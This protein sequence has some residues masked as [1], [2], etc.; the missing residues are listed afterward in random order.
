MFTSRAHPKN[1]GIGYAMVTISLLVAVYYNVILAYTLYYLAQSFRSVLPW[2]DCY[3]WWGAD[4]D[5]CF[6][7]Q[8]NVTLCQNIPYLLYQKYSTY[9][10]PNESGSWTPLT[11]HGSMFYVPLAE[12]AKLASSCSDFTGTTSAAEQFWERYVLELSPGIEYVGGLKWD[13]AFCLFVSWVIVFFC[14]IQGVSSSGKV[15]YFTAT[16]PYLVLTILLIKGV[17]LEGA[18]LGIEYFLV[19]DFSKLTS[20]TIWQKAAEQLFYSLGIGWGG[21]IMSGSY[22]NFRTA[23]AIDST[24]IIIADVLTSFLGG[25]AIFSVL[26][27]MSVTYGV[28]VDEVA[29]AGQGLAFVVYPEALTTFWC[30]QLWSVIFFV[31]LYLLGID[32]EFP[33]VQ[34]CLTVLFDAFPILRRHKS[35]TA[36]ITC[37]LCFLLGLTCVTRG[38]Q[39][40]LNLLDTYCAGVSLLTV[41]TIEIITLMWIYGVS[42]LSSDV[43][44]MLGARPNVLFRLSWAVFSPVLLLMLIAYYFYEWTPIKYN[45]TDPYPAWADVIG[46]LL[47]A[48]SVIQIPVI[49]VVVLCRTKSLRAAFR[50]A[51]N[52]GPADKHLFEDYRKYNDRRK[53]FSDNVERSHRLSVINGHA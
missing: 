32:S 49:A 2:A 26:G 28:P 44:F 7:R 14:L 35:V 41:A 51:F 21:L 13:L 42:N 40:V 25:I 43:K 45:N 3:E 33:L 36:F 29:K 5:T 4:K 24:I 52:W 20:L 34:T 10:S 8:K 22:N 12:H 30:P 11:H 53:S 15:V 16:F 23:I 37:T 6:V 39:Y 27:Y 9:L 17:T 18:I 19:P 38:G 46:L 1:L 50:P 48:A 31:M 47:A